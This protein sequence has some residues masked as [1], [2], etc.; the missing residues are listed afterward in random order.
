M[1]RIFQITAVGLIGLAA[2]FFWTGSTDAS[3]ASTVLGC[4]S[5]FLSIRAQ[6]KER[7]RTRDEQRQADKSDQTGGPD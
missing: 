7:N 4:V 2:Y 3:F 5:F 1:E 6:M